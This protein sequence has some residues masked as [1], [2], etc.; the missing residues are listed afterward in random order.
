M[1]SSDDF[2]TENAS[3][4]VTAIRDAASVAP[5]DKTEA[6]RGLLPAGLSD[7]LAPQAQADADA[8]EAVLSCFSQFG[9]QRIKPP[10][11]EFE[12]SLLADGPGAALADQTFRLLLSLIH[13]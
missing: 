13:I 12:N 2:D 4:S 1:T 7:L 11:L 8:V 10:L 5:T 3:A 9:Y 6:D